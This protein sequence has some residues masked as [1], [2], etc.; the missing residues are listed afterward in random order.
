M[1]TALCLPFLLA[2][3]VVETGESTEAPAPI[4]KT[5][6]GIAY[7]FIK[8]AFDIAASAAGLIVLFPLLLVVSILI[9]VDDPK[10]SPIFV[11]TRVGK[12]GKEFRFYKFRSMVVNAE[13]QLDDLMD[14][15][16]MDGPVFKI[17]DDPRITRV[18]KL[19]RRTSID[20]LPQ[21]WNVLRGDM[22]I[23]GP[24]PPVPREVKQYNSYQQQRLSVTPGLTCYWQV[25]KERNLCS[26]DEWVE[27]DLQY[28][29]ERSI[30]TDLK[31]IFKTFGAV[32]GMNG[33]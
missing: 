7:R 2:V 18:G 13:E 31:I 32:L 20:E 15:N 9:V 21:L 17:R 22:S 25:R 12:D 6:P 24:R 19:I 3:P 10:G 5:G 26:F 27:M 4:Q 11:Q 1:K 16:E 28:I 14:Q 29:R 8:R 33:Q 30:S 23:V